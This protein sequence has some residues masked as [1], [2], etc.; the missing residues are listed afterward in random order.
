M[1]RNGTLTSNSTVICQNATLLIT[2]TGVDMLFGVEVGLVSADGEL[3][4]NT[5]AM[6]LREGTYLARVPHLPNV[7]FTLLLMGQEA[8]GRPFQRQSSTQIQ[9]LQITVQDMDVTPPVC[10]VVNESLDCPV[11]CGKATWEVTLLMTDGNGT[12]LQNPRI[13]IIPVNETST[14][15]IDQ[16]KDENGYNA[17]LLTYRASCCVTI[18]EIS[19]VDSEGNVGRC[20]FSIRHTSTTG[21]PQTTISSTTSHPAFNISTTAPSNSQTL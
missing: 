5:S 8:D 20:D 18:V 11:P 6:R 7:P 14:A 13:S 9:A 19:A 10:H 15:I 17:T 3:L 21:P 4:R 1:K 2:V 16:V 12:G